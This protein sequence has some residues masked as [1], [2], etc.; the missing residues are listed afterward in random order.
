M[1]IGVECNAQFTELG[2]KK[3]FLIYFKRLSYNYSL[4]LL[5][6]IKIQNFEIVLKLKFKY[7]YREDPFLN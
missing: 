7:N 6:Q 4:Y 2:L 1:D 3:I 5:V